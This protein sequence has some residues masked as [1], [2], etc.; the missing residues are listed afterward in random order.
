MFKLNLKIALRNLWNNKG[1]TLIN[2]GGLG[3]GLA[4]CMILLLYV[5]NEWNYD[6]QFTNYENSYVV[7]NNIKASGKIFS[8]RVTPNAMAEEIKTKIPGVVYTSR[9]ADWGSQLISYGTKKFKKKVVYADPSFIKILDYKFIEGNPDK[10][11]REINTIILTKT[12]AK[13]LFGDVDPINKIV[14]FDN[15]ENLKVEAIIEDLPANTSITFDYLVPWAFAEKMR[16]DIKN[17]NWDDNSYLT[18]VQ[19]QEQRLFTKV[20][21]AIREIYVRND[22]N[23]NSEAFLHPLSKLHL[24]NEFENGKAVGGRIDQLKIFL[25][26][27]G[28]ILLIA[29]INFMNLTTAKSGKRAKEVGVRKA[30]G[31]SRKTLVVQFISESILISLLSTVVAFVLVEISLPYF[32][33]LLGTTLTIEYGNWKFWFA[34]FSLML[35]TGLLAGSYPALYLSSFESVKV[36]KGLTVKAGSSFAVRRVLVVFQF[37]FAACLIISTTVIYQQLNYIKNKPVGYNKNNLVQIEVEGNLN[38]QNKLELLKVQLIKSGAAAN[39]TFFNADFNL[40]SRNTSAVRWTGKN[41]TESTLFNYRSTGYDFVETMGTKMVGGREFSEK[42]DDSNSIVVNE[43]AV[44]AMGLKNPVGKTIYFWDTPV[45]VIGVMEDFVSGSA[46][47]KVEPMLFL[48]VTKFNAQVV[49]VRLNET[50]NIS[51]SLAKI[52]EVVK[53]MNPDYPV[54]RTFLDQSFKEKF[55]EEQLLGA[56]SN[57]FGGFAIFISCLGL[58]GLALFMAE[59]RKKEIS[60]R[61]VLGASTYS[62]LA[63]LNRDFMKLVVISNLIAFPVGYIMVNKWLSSFDYRVAISALPFVLAAV[64]SLIIALLT[65]SI[66]SVKV[67]KANPVDA[68]R[69]E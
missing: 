13:N 29:C 15:K 21:E 62:V 68:L 20:N 6:R 39:V 69:S 3:I 9:S 57:W 12:L 63:L 28:C 55:V 54:E 11:L 49:L 41:P 46:Y 19:L 14:K 56:L 53:G 40:H 65:V 17:P 26:L 60:I 38:D 16:P 44:N 32:N 52:D 35:F 42:Y 2:I 5:N 8:V 66:Q 18:L 23:T 7:Y 61:K 64:L 50:Q 1:F 24:Y 33:N 45:Q 25:I 48:P 67:A 59:Q 34:L 10:V 30:I 37:I 22:K 58:L 47:Q 27:A 51:S 43:A 36:M 4:S 31:S